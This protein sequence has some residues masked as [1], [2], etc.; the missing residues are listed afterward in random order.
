M[1]G[2]A[3]HDMMGDACG[4]VEVTTIFAPRGVAY[5]ELFVRQV[6]L[7]VHNMGMIKT[8]NAEVCRMFGCAFACVC[9]CTCDTAHSGFHMQTLKC[10]AD[11]HERGGYAARGAQRA[12]VCM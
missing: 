9:A 3:P 2:L 7:D 6:Y 11:S 1:L 5:H 8:A 4:V 12:L 10:G